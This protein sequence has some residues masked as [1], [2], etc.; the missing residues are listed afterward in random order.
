MS[1]G[2]WLRERRA[3]AMLSQAALAERAEVYETT[4]SRLE[5]GTRL[6][7]AATIRRI[8]RA[9]GEEVETAGPPGQVLSDL[10]HSRRVSQLTLGRA[11]GFSGQYISHL[12]EGRV[13]LS[14]RVALQLQAALIE[15]DA[16]YWLRLQLDVDLA[17]ARKR[18]ADELASIRLRVADTM[19]PRPREGHPP[20]ETPPAA[21][22]FRRVR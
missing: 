21:S 17:E 14:T 11:L 4:I 1:F 6:P 15:P 2:V 9:L 22:H 13:R 10:L 18:M 7:R 3:A 20:G 12:I 16:A 5:R 19:G 8:R